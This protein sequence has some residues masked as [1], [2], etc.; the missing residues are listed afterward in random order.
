MHVSS[1]IPQAECSSESSQ[2]LQ[3]AVAL[4]RLCVSVNHKHTKSIALPSSDPAPR[5]VGQRWFQA[6]NIHGHL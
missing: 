6:A 4:S 5:S 2:T 1:R 3:D